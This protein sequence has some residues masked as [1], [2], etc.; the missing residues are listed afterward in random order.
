MLNVAIMRPD[1]RS[2]SRVELSFAN[3]NKGFIEAVRNDFEEIGVDKIYVCTDDGSVGRKGY[4]PQ[5]LD[6]DFSIGNLPR[7]DV[8]IYACGP[9]NMLQSVAEL[10]RRHSVKCQV[11]LEER[12]A[13][14]IG[15]CLSCTCD[16]YA[17][18]G[19]IEKKRVCRDGPVFQSREIKW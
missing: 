14:G 5:I 19:T 11:L 18:N 9:R 13:C 10:A 3:G 15:A 1:S 12:M 16:A 8:E 7:T 4:V 17:A 6:E 2:D